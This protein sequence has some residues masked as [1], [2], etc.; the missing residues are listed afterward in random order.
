MLVISGCGTVWG[1]SSCPSSAPLSPAIST[2]PTPWLALLRFALTL[3]HHFLGFRPH[4][5]SWVCQEGKQPRVASPD[6]TEGNFKC[7]MNSSK[8]QWRQERNHQLL[9]FT[10][11]Q[12]PE[13]TA[14]M[15]E[16]VTRKWPSTSFFPP[17]QKRAGHAQEHQCKVFSDKRPTML[18]RLLM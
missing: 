15:A 8:S 18:Y 1:G 9:P 13:S 5:V 7:R 12:S 11:Y 16:K 17:K 4:P 14:H 3:V 6:S 10:Y 2:L